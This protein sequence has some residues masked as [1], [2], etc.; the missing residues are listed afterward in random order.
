R[1]GPFGGRL[2]HDVEPRRRLCVDWA[3]AQRGSHRRD[4]GGGAVAQ[5][6]HG[7]GSIAPL[8]DVTLDV[9][10]A[11]QHRS[12]AP[13]DHLRDFTTTRRVLPISALA[14]VISVFAAFVAAALLATISVRW[15]SSFRSP[16][17]SPSA[18]WRATDRSGSADTASPK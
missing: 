7:H 14:I 3:D 1:R 16:V 15:S 4:R 13:L 17:R 2:C 6:V 8:D 5:T 9:W 12:A 11:M 18:S 10:D